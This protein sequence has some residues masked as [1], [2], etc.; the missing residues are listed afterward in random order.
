MPERVVFLDETAVKTNLTRQRGWSPRGERL[1]ADTPFGIW[2]T[3]TL[4]A[5]LIHEELIAP[6]VIKG[7]CLT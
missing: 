4:I 5:G 1:K 3:Q 7:R 6:W 2:G